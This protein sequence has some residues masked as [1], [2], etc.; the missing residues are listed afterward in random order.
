M[1]RVLYDNAVKYDADVSVCAFRIIA[2]DGKRKEYAR[3]KLRI[4]NG[5]NAILKM[6]TEEMTFNVTPFNKLIKQK[7]LS[8]NG[9]R[10]DTTIQCCED[11]L[12]A[13]EVF[14]RSEKTVQYCMP[15]YNYFFH[16]ESVTHQYGLTEQRK[17]GLV[18][19][20]RVILSESDKKIKKRLMAYKFVVIAILCGEY[21]IQK[22]YTDG[23][24]LM[25][26]NYILK[27]MKY[28]LFGF[29]SPVKI[30]IKCCLI[31]IPC[32]YRFAYFIWRLLGMP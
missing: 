17:T 27:N 18:T 28:I 24:F 5:Q 7:L 12:L 14:R 13:Y 15:Y 4:Y 1:F 8:E 26:K 10:F 3:D 16:S 20:D 9:L 32:L 2:S 19:I 31:F 22:D 30:K 29:S 21:I 25:L 23:N 11:L 6:L